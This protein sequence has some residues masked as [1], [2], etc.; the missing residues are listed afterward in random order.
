MPPIASTTVETRIVG[1]TSLGHALCHISMLVLPAVL[2]PIATEYGLT[3]TELTAVGTLAYL[4][5]GL[6]AIPSGIISDVTSAK[7]MLILFFLGTAVAAVM[8]VLA[9]SFALF[10]VGMAVL[11]LA[12]SIYHVAGPTLNSHYSRRTGKS[13]GIHGVFGSAG[14]TI[15]PLLA[16]VLASWIGW[17]AAYAFL[18]P[19]G[20]LGGIALLVD[21]RIP[22]TKPT[23]QA[24]RRQDTGE[25]RVLTFVL[26]M[27]AMGINGFVYRAFL[28]MFP[29]YIA[30]S[31]PIA[32]IS[33]V[34]SGGV[35]ASVILAFG[36]VGQYGSGIIADRTDRFRLYTGILLIAAPVLVLVGVF[37]GWVLLG[38]AIVFS[39]VYFAM[40]PVENSILGTYVPPRL[41]SSVF[42]MK[43]VMV[44]GIGSLGSVFSGYVA[45]GWG[46][47]RLYVVLGPITLVAA[48]VS[49]VAM[50]SR[51]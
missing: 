41:V 5:F 8:I 10:V 47:G 7:F 2:A 18:I 6:G 25:A 17:R 51:S 24:Q 13:F 46:L 44:F 42:G 28:T 36:M 39:L 49:I 26:L 31:V 16:G 3:L 19:V 38:I 34:L 50:R 12:A 23:V 4:L 35:L 14:I 32:R 37:G 33:P 27:L 11:G 1:I 15:A 29:T 9:P 30:Q 45:D 21:R 43:F 48:L 20:L 40:Q 22:Y